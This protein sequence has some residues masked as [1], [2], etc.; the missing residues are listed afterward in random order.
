MKSNPRYRIPVLCFVAA[1][2]LLTLQAA[3]AIVLQYKGQAEDK[4]TYKYSLSGEK[5]MT[6]LTTGQTM[7]TKISGS[8]TG[9]T[10][11]VSA[12]SEE[13]ELEVAIL[14][15]ET[16]TTTASGQKQSQPAEKSK[17]WIRMTPQGKMLEIK[18]TKQDEEMDTSERVLRA[19]DEAGELPEGDVNVGDVWRKSL[20]TKEPGSSQPIPITVESKLLGIV[21]FK[22]HS[23]AKIKITFQ[24]PLNSHYVATSGLPAGAS[25]DM[26]GMISGDTIEFFD[27]KL[28]QQ[29]Y[30]V[31]T[32]QST[33]DTTV[34]SQGK[35]Q[36]I[37]SQAYISLKS[38]LV[39]PAP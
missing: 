22:G 5:I 30:S 4:F 33:F 17:H 38:S 7:R 14:S 24:A 13:L 36:E 37:K 9:V 28:G 3:S 34:R 32:L 21:E 19:I 18:P 2:L 25:A 11:V 10:R 12:S 26:T 29:V 39:E 8:K 6:N 1:L 16:T 15:G 20:T 31:A 23:C 27:P 35:S